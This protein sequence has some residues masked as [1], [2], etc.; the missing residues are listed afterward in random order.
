MCRT[1]EL[2]DQLTEDEVG[3]LREIARGPARRRIPHTHAETLLRL[4]FAE[5]VYGYQELTIHGKRAALILGR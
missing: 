1:M 2:M 5:L 3:S 4:G